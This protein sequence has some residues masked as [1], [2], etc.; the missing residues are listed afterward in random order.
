MWALTRVSDGEFN[1]KKYEKKVRTM[2]YNGNF[3]YGYGLG[4]LVVELS[5]NNK[6]ALFRLVDWVEPVKQEKT[7]MMN[8]N[9][10]HGIMLLYFVLIGWYAEMAKCWNLDIVDVHLISGQKN[11]MF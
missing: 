10:N 1:G 8:G 2:D 11:I 9:E 7:W 5:Q 4:I 3:G 6:T